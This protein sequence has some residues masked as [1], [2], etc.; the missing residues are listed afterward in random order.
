M[1]VCKS[2]GASAGFDAWDVGGG[3]G[4][5]ED[6]VEEGFGGQSASAGVGEVEV[7]VLVPF[8]A[9]QAQLVGAALGDDFHEVAN[10]EA[11]LH[12]LIGEIL[13][14]LGVTGRVAC[15][16]VVE[17]FDDAGA[18]EVT[19]NAIGVAHGEVVVFGAGQPV[20]KGFA[21]T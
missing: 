4:D 16:D 1:G 13:K 19:P 18:G 11:A 20:G 12:E 15:A 10:V 21:A 2:R 14:E 7:V 9:L 3:S 6:A 5:G 8:V 17:G